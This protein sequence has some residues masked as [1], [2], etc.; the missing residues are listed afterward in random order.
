M[1]WF[2]RGLRKGIKTEKEF[3]EI[4]PWAT[5]LKGEGEFTECPNKALEKGWNPGKCIFCRRC[6]PKYS[7]SGDYR[8]GSRE[9]EGGGSAKGQRDG[10]RDGE[11]VIPQFRRSFYLYP[12]DVGSCGACNVEL[13]LISS[14][15]YDTTRF[16]IFFTNTPKHAD[17]LVVMEVLTEK[18]EDALERAYEAMPEPKLVI[19]LGTCATSGGIFGRGVRADVMIPGCLPSP[20][21]IIDAIL[22]ARGDKR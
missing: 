15:Q 20:P 14:P 13:K 22:K 21:T 3:R 10:E 18:M 1:S 12:I 16:G 6:Y 2:I 11:R 19:A 4:A 17:A 7:P 9:W 5:S 8:M